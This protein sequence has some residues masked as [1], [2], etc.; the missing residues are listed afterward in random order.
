MGCQLSAVQLAQAAYKLQLGA[1]SFQGSRGSFLAV[2]SQD[3]GSPALPV[4]QPVDF[5]SEVGAHAPDEAERLQEISEGYE[6]LTF[7]PVLRGHLTRIRH[8]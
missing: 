6:H 3:P 2:L 5:P 4:I 8:Q 7:S 1:H